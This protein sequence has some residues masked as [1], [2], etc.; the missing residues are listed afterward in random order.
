MGTA[1][2]YQITASSAPQS[3]GVNTL[4]SGL[5]LN[6]QTGLISGT[7]AR[8]NNHQLRLFAFYP[9]Y[10]ASANLSLSIGAI[11]PAITSPATHTLRLGFYSSYQITATNFP[12]SYGAQNLPPG[13]SIDTN[14]GTISGVPT[15]YTGTLT[16]TIT[17]TNPAGTTSRSLVFATLQPPTF[18][19]NSAATA[20]VGTFHSFQTQATGTNTFYSANNLPPGLLINSYSGLITGT[21]SRSGSYQTTLQATN[22]NGI[23]RQT[24]SYTILAAQPL[25]TPL[26]YS[27]ELGKP[28]QGHI[29]ARN[30]PTS[31]SAQGLPPGISL[32]SRTGRLSGIPTLIGNFTVSATASNSAGSDTKP[33]TIRVRGPIPTL[34]SPTIAYGH[35]GKSFLYTIRATNNPSSYTAWGLPRGLKLNSQTGTLS[36]TPQQTGNFYV[37][38]GAS[39]AHGTGYSTLTLIISPGYYAPLPQPPS[40]RP[41]PTR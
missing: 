28:F 1:F 30:E 9:N 15:Q 39:N 22:T 33:L 16:S 24:L 19:N 11:L 27:G 34:T 29:L 8:Y 26:S 25:I 37:S 3:W 21:P 7:P 5:T 32:D 14:R 13:L 41:L 38:L 40:W 2:S 6:T 4:P 20:T 36:G 35:T 10:T 17:A 23:G 18:T 31:F 12:T